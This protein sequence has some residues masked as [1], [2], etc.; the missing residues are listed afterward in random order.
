MGLKIRLFQADDYEEV[1]RISILAFTPIFHSFQ[2]I[3][4]KKVF[5]MLYPDWKKSQK[6][7]IEKV[8]G[9]ERFTIW[10]GELDH[11]VIGFLVVEYQEEELTGEI[12]LLAVHPDHQKY[13]YGTRLNQFALKRM[14]ERGMRLAV[15]STGGDEAHLPARKTYEKTG[16]IGLPMIR[17]Y[18]AL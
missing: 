7:G 16:Y 13:G 18:K 17:Y 5:P 2:S 10:V 11:K 14:K 9:E 8:V 1:V 4:G 3:L 15:V 6:D 12:H